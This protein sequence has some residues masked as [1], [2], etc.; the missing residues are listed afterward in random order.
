MSKTFRNPFSAIE[1][2]TDTR[3]R[4]K[5]EEDKGDKTVDAK[6]HH[7]RYVIGESNE[8]RFVDSGGDQVEEV[9]ERTV[10]LAPS[11]HKMRDDPF[12]YDRSLVQRIQG[13]DQLKRIKELNRIDHCKEHEIVEVVF[14][15]AGVECCAMTKEDADKHQVPLQYIAGY[16]LGKSDGLVKIGR[17][18]TQLDSGEAYYEHINIIP[19]AVVREMICLEQSEHNME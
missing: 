1:I 17:S 6:H 9:K 4:V 19:Q 7:V 13:E 11:I 8:K 16:L 15:S 10:Y 18:K 12:H 5:S 3:L 2:T 14:E